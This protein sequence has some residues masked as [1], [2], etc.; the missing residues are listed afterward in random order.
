[1]HE[2]ELAGAIYGNIEVELAFSGLKLGE[3][4][5]E[6]AARIGL[7]LLLWRLEA[8]GVR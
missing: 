7:E 1:L 4:N 8:F 6:I 5:V 3:V 2:G